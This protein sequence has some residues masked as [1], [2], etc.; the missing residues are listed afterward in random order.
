MTDGNLSNT[1]RNHNHPHRPP[2]QRRPRRQRRRHR[3]LLPLPLPRRQCRHRH[4]LGRPAA[5]PAVAAG[6]ALRQRRR[7]PRDRAEG[8][9][10]PRLHQGA[11]PAAGAAGQ[12]EL[13][14]GHHGGVYPDADVPDRRISGGP[15]DQGEA[16][17]EI[18]AAVDQCYGDDTGGSPR[19]FMSAKIAILDIDRTHITPIFPSTV[20][21]VHQRRCIIKT[22]HL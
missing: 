13:Q 15:V 20:C 12:A 18:E 17:Q 11:G 10:E 9:P 2:R 16:A 19:I 1:H 14:D 3:L 21:I 5:D 6:R 7:G 4:Q 8:P 22:L